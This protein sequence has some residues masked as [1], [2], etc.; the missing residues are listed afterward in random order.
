M[1][2]SLQNFLSKLS[3]DQ[4][5]TTN[6][7]E[8]S[9]I[10]PYPDVNEIV[11]EQITFFAEGFELPNRQQNFADVAFKGYNVP[12]P[13]NVTMSQ[14]HNITVRADSEGKLRRAFL[15]WQNNVSNTQNVLTN[16]SFLSGDKKYNYNSQ[17]KIRLLDPGD[18]TKV[19]ETYTMYGVR[20]E[21]V[22]GFQVSNADANV[23]TFTV[24]FRS[25][26]WE[27]DKEYA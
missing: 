17:I 10:S 6:L 14:T 16:S 19:M 7:F 11:G 21:D 24:S 12:V 18:T 4:L 23:A 25:V 5:R 2:Q 26:W 1:A 13:T 15:L 27:T 22:G 20:I 8:V 3:T 9:L